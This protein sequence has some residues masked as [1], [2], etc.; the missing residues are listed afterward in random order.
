MRSAIARALRGTLA[1]VS[2]LAFI[3]LFLALEA[4][5]T[6]P[7]VLGGLAALGTATLLAAAGRSGVQRL[8]GRNEWGPEND[9]ETT[10]DG[11]EWLDESADDTPWT[12][13]ADRAGDGSETD[14]PL[15]RLEP[16]LDDAWN[17]WSDAALTLGLAALGIGSLVLL[18]TYPGEEPP[19]GLLLLVAFGFNGALVTLPF[20]FKEG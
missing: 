2:L 4:R 3:S 20:V 18:A 9:G 5:V 11:D 13:R 7:A 1:A 14:W 16:A 10:A 12:D 6:S 8:L 19:L 17:R 15:A